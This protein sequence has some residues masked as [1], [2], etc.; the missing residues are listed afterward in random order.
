MGRR[1]NISQKLGMQHV[2]TTAYHP[3]SNGLV[4]RFHC[5]LKEGLCARA[6]GAVWLQHLPFVLLGLHA[7]PKEEANVSSA[8]AVLGEQPMLPGQPTLP[9]PVLRADDRPQIPYTVR[10]YAN[11]VASPPSPL[12]GVSFAYVHREPSAVLWSR[13]SGGPTPFWTYVPRP[14]SCKSATGWSG[15]QWTEWNLT[16]ENPQWSQ[17]NHPDVAVLSRAASVEP[18]LW[19]LP[20]AWGRAVS[21]RCCF[22]LWY[23]FAP[24]GGGHV[25]TIKC[26]V[27]CGENLQRKSFENPP[28]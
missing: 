9:Q 16:M 12:Q 23:I 25:T 15:C 18:R 11:M 5:Q 20:A 14:L 2:M 7:A 6:S 28:I 8:E 1:H 10:S 27:L 3:Q 4:E 24:S 26:D 21:L 13:S 19:T 17:L 22:I